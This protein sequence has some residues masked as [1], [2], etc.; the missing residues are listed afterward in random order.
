MPEE[1]SRAMAAAISGA[2]LE[3]IEGSGHALVVEKPEEFVRV[4]LA[5]LEDVQRTGG[6]S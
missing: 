3:V 4:C 2:S 1:R 5:F 6:P